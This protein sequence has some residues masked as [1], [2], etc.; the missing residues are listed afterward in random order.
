MHPFISLVKTSFNVYYGISAFKY[1]YFQQKKELWRPVVGILGG[2]AGLLVLTGTYS[3]LAGAFYAGGKM[4]GQP[5]LV[6][7][8]A[9]LLGELLV[10]FFGLGWTISVLYFSNDLPILLPL[11]LKPQQILLSKFLLVLTNQYV[12]LLFVFL[13]PFLIYAIGERAGFLYYLTALAVFLCAP[14]IP[15]GL[16]T[17]GGSGSH[18][19]GGG[20]FVLPPCPQG[21]GTLPENRGVERRKVRLPVFLNFKKLST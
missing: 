17:S 15:Q 6:L 16:A 18:P 11:P 2:G 10:F 13:P 19:G 1:K 9:I 4:L 21:S 8:L 12:F 7:E 20:V 5:W 14:V 3:S